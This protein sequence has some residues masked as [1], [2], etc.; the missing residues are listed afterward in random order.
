MLQKVMM[1]VE[2]LYA[3]ISRTV[4]LSKE[5]CAKQTNRSKRYKEN[6]EPKHMCAAVPAL[7]GG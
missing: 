6:D 5:P 3:A 2:D 7:G 1:R 4:D